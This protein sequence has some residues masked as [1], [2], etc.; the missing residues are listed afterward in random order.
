MRTVILGN[1]FLYLASRSL[2][3]RRSMVIKDYA[4]SF[5]AYWVK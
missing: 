3:S 4:H 2:N 5:E 1:N